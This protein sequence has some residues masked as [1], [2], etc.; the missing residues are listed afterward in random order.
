LEEE[1]RYMTE[2]QQSEPSLLMELGVDGFFA[3]KFFDEKRY[4]HL[5]E[6]GRKS[7]YD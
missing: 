2:I 6:G 1:I 3:Q 7:H 5:Y 4:D